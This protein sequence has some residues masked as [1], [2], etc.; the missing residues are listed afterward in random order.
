MSQ[1][2]TADIPK[3]PKCHS[4]DNLTRTKTIAT[5]GPVSS[6]RDMLV[7]LIKAGVDIFRLNM[8]HSNRELHQKAMDDIRW[9][10]REASEEVGVLVD[11]AGPKIRLGQMPTEPIMI[12]TGSQVRFV[13]QA[14]TDPRDLTCSYENLI[15]EVNVGDPIM[16]CD[17]TV[18]LE[19][20][21][22][23]QDKVFCHVVDGGEIR[24]RQGV[25]LPG[26]NLS[27]S[28]ISEVDR[29]N[30]IWAA[31]AGADFISLSFVRTPA[32]IV[33]LKQMVAE[34]GSKALV[35]AKI[36]KRE[37]LDNI[38]AIVKES[39]GIM[40][41]R[42]DLG[43]EI[44]I[45]KT[46]LAQKMIIKTCQ[47]FGK[48]VIVATQMLESMRHSKQPTRAEASDVANA[49][50]DGADACMLSG[51][52]AIGD[53]PIDAVRIMQ[54]I[55]IETEQM[56]RGR[57]SRYSDVQFDGSPRVSDA[58]IRGAALVARQIG[59]RAVAIATRTGEA[60]LVKSKQRDFIPTFALTDDVTILRRMKIFW[61]VE[62]LYF[63]Q[64]G[65][66]SQVIPFV[67]GWASD[68][69]TVESGQTIVFVID[70]EMWPGVND[71]ILVSE[72]K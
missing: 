49:I 43:V 14:T 50:L 24:S 26:A 7:Q 42:G 5:L 47:R 70:T 2:Q 33:E 10:S 32:E 60:A 51:E 55:K 18:R 31:N 3:N 48:P 69:P 63:E 17:G 59:A 54:K 46:P 30:A 45:E 65:D 34:A 53:F 41:A 39:D 12:E 68:D 27:V 19:V 35:I 56:L 29:S 13:R 1:T 37:A 6:S 22:K 21:S 25:N 11:L 57:P 8:A 9:A 23:D 15:D 44:E 28:A 64:M 20:Q 58:I 72:I 16:L 36:E 71:M 4:L 67:R 38:D 52:T 66:S 61:G 62:P 40:V